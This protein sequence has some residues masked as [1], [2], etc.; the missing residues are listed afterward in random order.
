M[1]TKE[2]TQAQRDKV[3]AL[4]DKAGFPDGADPFDAKVLRAF[5]KEKNDAIKDAEKAIANTYKQVDAIDK[6]IAIVCPA[7]AK[8]A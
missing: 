1:A 5:R 4:L 8:E 3:C 7:K 6:A 2:L